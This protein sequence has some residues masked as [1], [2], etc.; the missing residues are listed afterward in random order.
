MAKSKSALSWTM[1]VLR[2]FLT[3]TVLVAQVL[4]V[5]RENFKTCS[6][7]GFCKRQRAVQPGQSPYVALLDSIQK[8][9]TS[10]QLQ[11]LN[12]HNNVRFLLQ[13]FGLKHNT[14]RV[15]L[16][17][18]EPLRARY[19]IPVGETLK[20]QPEAEQI[21]VQET[22]RDRVTFSLGTSKVVILSDPFRMDFF[23]GGEPVV[24][25]NSQELLKFEHMR[26]KQGW[27]SRMGSGLYSWFSAPFR[28]EQQPDPPAEDKGEEEKKEGEEEEGKQVPPEKTDE[29]ADMWEETFKSFTDSKPHGP[30]SVGIDISFPGFDFVYGIPEH[31]D[32][33]ALKSTKNTEPYRLFNLDVFEYELYNP[34]ALYGS[35]PLMLAHNKKNTVGI[36]WHNAAETWID[37]SST[38]ADKTFF[39][40]VADMV[41]GSTELPRT[42]THWFSESGVIDLFV[43]LGSRPKDVFYQYGV[44]TG[45]TELP[46]LFSIA[47]HQCRWNYND[48]D[49][50][51]SVA[52]NFD[53]H[54][55]PFD[56]IW[57]DIE[58]TDGKRYFTWAGDKFPNP[59]EMVDNLVSRGRKLV[60]IVDPH[61]KKDDNYHVYSDLKARDYY[62][63]NKDNGEYEGWCWPGSS[64]WPDF[65]NPAVQEWWA[66]KFAY[67][68]YPGSSKDVFVWNDMN[69]PSVFNGPEIT[70]Q[71]DVK[72]HGDLENRDVHNLYGFLVHKATWDGLLKRSDGHLRPFLLTRAF[73]AGSQRYGA[74]WTGDNIGEWSHLKAANPMIMSLNIVGIT[75]S[76]AD[77]GGFFR[78]PDTELVTRWYQAGAFY[79]FFR[80]HAH[81][82]TKRR[83]PYLL[84]EE[85]MK[86]IRD[87]VR[88]RYTLLSYMY[89]QFYKSMESGSPIFQ[90]MWVEFPEETAVFG[91][92]DQFML[93]P[94]L[95]VKPVT[96]QGASTTTVY[97][98]GAGQL[99][100]DLF[101]YDIHQGDQEKSV[102]GTLDKIP[103][104]QRGGTIVPR[105]M[106]IR[107]SSTLMYDD[108]FT[109]VVCLDKQGEAQGELYADDY[110]T[111]QFKNGHYVYRGFTY[112]GNTLE[113]KNLDP[114][115]SYPTKEW[116][117]KVIIAG[118]TKAPKTVVLRSAGVTK[119]LGFNL[120]SAKHVL[121]IRKPGVNIAQDFTISVN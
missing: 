25:I 101:T 77:V 102:A 109:L 74:V 3:V 22:S 1:C 79:P 53:K 83:E 115:G 26:Q 65:F 104:Y 67:T 120:D 35:V 100:Y 60:T 111:F 80:A 107:R 105:K 56:V 12:K 81:L 78:N 82:D 68:E 16:N 86:V 121:T 52:E 75:F 18:L 97:F 6:Q 2:S 29:E 32:S 64:A 71:K 103:A 46:P 45:T 24:S 96:E 59:Q 62:V 44:L 38:V 112:K 40:K 49:D 20:S 91:I 13:V 98:P 33:L 118:V 5:N 9:S 54:D 57:L 31:A 114:K 93:G 21:T 43:L 30:T 113:S 116:L 48:E 72:H 17:E 108:P 47:Y 87:A 36:F 39:S 10:I 73:F 19:E 58:H 11:L 88:T 70:F 27:L 95:L 55:I 99:W 106:R 61:L 119:N 76:G 7:S 63:K 8:T 50:V 84:P 4:S 89:T 42:D 14:V 66:G 41:K 110:H 94:A 117:E 34:M 37:I 69:E 23:A 85:N 90:P 28:A 51:K 92:D 15:K